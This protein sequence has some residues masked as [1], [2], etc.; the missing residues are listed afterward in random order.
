MEKAESKQEA[1][2]LIEDAGMLLTD[3][4]PDQVAGGRTFRSGNDSFRNDNKST[5]NH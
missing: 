4:E 5:S 1:K 2:K 3:G